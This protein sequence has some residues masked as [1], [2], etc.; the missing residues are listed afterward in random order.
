M[1]N[2][3]EY[4]A[5]VGVALANLSKNQDRVSVGHSDINNQVIYGN[6]LL[7]RTCSSDTKFSSP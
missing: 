7:L 3:T 2:E 1:I 5:T 4:A 6:Y